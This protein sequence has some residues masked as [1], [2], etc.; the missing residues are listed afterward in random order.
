MRVLPTRWQ[1]KPAGIKIT[2]L[3]PCVYP[4]VVCV[5]VGRIEAL[6]HMIAEGKCPRRRKCP[7]GWKMSD[8]RC[9]WIDRPIVG[10]V[11]TA[12]SVCIKFLSHLEQS[13]S[14]CW[15]LRVINYLRCHLDV[16][17]VLLITL[18]S[19]ADFSHLR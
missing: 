11:N 4:V 2:S 5:T 9:D 10:R 14:H 13:V 1:R 18:I 3:S 6:Q 7:R 17:N 16:K 8:T 19:W 15:S 12:V